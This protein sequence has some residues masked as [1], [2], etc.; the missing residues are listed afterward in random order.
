MSAT[1]LVVERDEEVREHLQ[2]ALEAEGLSVVAT[3]SGA[4][5]LHLTELYEPALIVM[6]AALDDG[7]GI[8]ACE[9]LQYITQAPVLLVGILSPVED[10]LIDVLRDVDD[11][12]T[13]PFRV[14]E[15]VARAMR[16]LRE[17]PAAQVATQTPVLEDPEGRMLRLG[18]LALDLNTHALTVGEREVALSPSQASVLR[19]LIEHS[20]RVVSPELLVARAWPEGSRDQSALGDAMMALRDALEKDPVHPQRIIHVAGYGYK[21]LPVTDDGEQ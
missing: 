21:I 19:V 5:A 12:V 16:L 15:V 1:I 20:P 11:Y 14:T 6:G 9:R 18:D 3:P 7:S 17:R 10:Q 2:Q 4:R 13:R 8:D